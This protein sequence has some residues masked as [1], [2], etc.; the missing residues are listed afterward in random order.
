MS[1]Q[2]KIVIKTLSKPTNEDIDTLTDWF[3]KVFDLASEKDTLEPAMLSEII[4]NSVTGEGTTSKVLNRKLSAPRSTVIYH[5]NRFIYTGLVV[6]KGRRYYLR[7]ED[8]E[9][10]IEEMQADIEREFN[11]MLEF[12]QKMDSLLESGLYGKRRR[13]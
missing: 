4:K 10:T 13:K 1:S 5:L 11:R 7:S 8:M 2:E 3:C 12:A 9:G 6:R